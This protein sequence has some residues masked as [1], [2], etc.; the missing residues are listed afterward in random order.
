M[1]KK[2]VKPKTQ[3]KFIDIEAGL[4]GN[5]KFSSPV[6]LRISGKFEGELETIGSLIIAEKQR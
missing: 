2:K 3:E 5:V 6:N 1:F 4:Q